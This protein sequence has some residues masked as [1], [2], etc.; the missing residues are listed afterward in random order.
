MKTSRAG[1]NA[2]SWRRGRG[3][4]LQPH[5]V[6]VLFSFKSQ[7]SLSYQV[8]KLLGYI[9]WGGEMSSDE[10]IIDV[11]RRRDNP[12]W[13]NTIRGVA[14][15]LKVDP[16]CL[17]HNFHKLRREG[18]IYMLPGYRSRTRYRLTERYLKLS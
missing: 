17:V 6:L 3:G 9:D 11:M 12:V 8:K 2:P 7:I 4:N 10:E 14:H 16:R 15:A 18:V 13:G 5:S 1:I